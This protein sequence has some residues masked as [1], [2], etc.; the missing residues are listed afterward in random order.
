MRTLVTGGAGFVG[1]HLVEKLLDQGHEVICLEREGAGRSWLKGLDIDFQPC[2]LEDPGLLEKLVCGVDEVYHLAALT[3]A[4]RPEDCYR[5]NTLGTARILE[6]ASR[7]PGGPPRLVLM[8]SLAAVGPTQEG[9]SITE[10]IPPHPLSHYGRSK[11][12]AEA[13]VHAYQ[14]RVPATICRFP[15]VYG[16]R[17]HVVLKLFQMVAR[18]FAVTVG[19]WDRTVSVVHVNDAVDGLLAAIRTPAAMGRIY[20]VAHPEAITWGD[21]V[22]TIGRALGRHPRMLAVPVAVARA[23]AVAAEAL[24]LVQRKAAILN[25]ERVRE[26]GQDSWL[27]DP[28][29]AL[30]EIG[31]QPGYALGPGIS[32]TARWLRREKWIR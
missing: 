25:R 22:T 4:R 20:N 13:V 32:H 31:F 12:Q 1:S 28:A 30:N 7:C 6:A 26:L 29:N 3:E 2:G 10:D 16:P 14:D 11:L 5:V 27:C 24:A 23:I 21:F 9:G 17:D 8:S 15:A 18:G 19:P